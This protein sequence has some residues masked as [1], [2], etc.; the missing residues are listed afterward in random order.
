MKIKKVFSALLAAALLASAAIPM[1]AS[2]AADSIS[3]NGVEGRLKNNEGENQVEFCQWSVADDGVMTLT[4]MNQRGKDCSCYM[5]LKNDY[6]FV[7]LDETPFL[8]WDVEGSDGMEFDILLRYGEDDATHLVKVAKMVSNSDSMEVGKGKVNLLEKMQSLNMD[9]SSHEI[10]F[11]VIKFRIY[12]G[13]ND[14]ATFKKVYFGPE[15]ADDVTPSTVA[16]PAPTEGEGEESTDAPG[17]TTQAADETK[18]TTSTAP[19][20]AAKTTAKTTAADKDAEGTDTTVI[21]IVVVAAVVVVAAA[22]G[23]VIYL[24]KKKK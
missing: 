5:S 10:P 13:K 6:P 22:V 3:F 7:N 14:T 16:P 15:G 1:S 18:D 21:V 11:E 17:D 20:T 9:L 2:A 23:V 8:Y 24:K 12:G 4:R 19:A